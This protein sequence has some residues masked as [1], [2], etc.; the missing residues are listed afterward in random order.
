MQKYIV[1]WK[2]CYS[3]NVMAKDK[4]EA[5]KKA[6]M[7]VDQHSDEVFFDDYEYIGAELN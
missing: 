2:K 7:K 3:I 4:D 1:R 5:I 6:D